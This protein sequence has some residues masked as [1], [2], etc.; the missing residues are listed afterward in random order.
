MRSPHRLPVLAAALALGALLPSASAFAFQETV[1][2][3]MR[4]GVQ[5]A[6]EVFRPDGA[7]TPRPVILRRTPYGRAMDSNTVNALLFYGFNVVSQDVRGRGGSGGVFVPFMD[8]HND[9]PDTL[10]WIAQQP[11]SNGS[12]GTYS[13]SAEGIVQLMAAGEGPPALK[14]AHVGVATGDVYEGIMPG[15]AWRKELTTDWLVGLNEPAALALLRQHEASDS[16]WDPVRLTPAKRAKVKAPV[17][18]YGG[19]FDIFSKDTAKAHRLL[20]QEADPSVRGDM[21]LVLGP[22]TH[23]GINTNVQG[24]VTFPA[25]AAYQQLTNEFASWIAWCLMGS[26]RPS[27]QA[28]RYYRMKLSD[29]G[30]SATG[31]WLGTDTWPPASTATTFYVH[32][33]LSL[34]TLP[35]RANGIASTLH[36]DPAA[37]IPSR[38]G[39]NLNTAAGPMDQASVDSLG[40]VLTATTLP[41]SVEVTVAGDV[42]ARVWAASSSTDADAIVRLS[43]VTP[44]GRVMMLADGVRRG[45]FVQSTDALQPLTPGQPAAFDIEV[46]PVAFVLPKG[47]ALRLSIQATSSPRYE[48]NPGVGT[49]LAQNPAPV[50][51]DLT[52]Y[53]DP[54]HPSTVTLPIVSGSIPLPSGSDAGMPA[55]ATTVAPADGSLAA[56]DDAGT[57]TTPDDGGGTSGPVDGGAPS[58]IDGA[59]PPTGDGGAAIASDGGA[60]EVADGSTSSGSDTGTVESTDSGSVEPT[61]PGGCGCSSAAGAW[62]ALLVLGASLSLSIRVR[63]RR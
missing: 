40:G 13:A 37:P 61:A 34:S 62:P 11:F 48:P 3:S 58:S 35:P 33:D 59:L 2:V 57:P 16:Y 41:A 20:Q 9:G 15:G 44:G 4:D 36:S 22:W 7:V 43:Q 5:L 56:L 55:D 63:R 50:A 54:T 45:R 1:M 51:Y 18:L 42:T 39:G 30:R 49:P 53:R 10:A 29:D 23:G 24:E 38:G 26:T 19:F 28:V 17:F 6:T 47:H 14:C 27:W 25:D 32:D 21:F 60:T 31:Q 12:V 8:D 46:G 52:V